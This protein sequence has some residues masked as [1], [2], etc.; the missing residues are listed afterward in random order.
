M[1]RPQHFDNYS[2]IPEIV[3][4]VFVEPGDA[5]Y[6]VDDE[7]EIVSWNCDEWND[8]PEAVTATVNAVALAVS[9]GAN[10]VRENIK[11]EG[12]VLRN[13]IMDTDDSRL[14]DTQLEQ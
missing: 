14:N 10:A 2:G 3:P 9:K 12:Q 4:G 11:Q 5:V 13:L 1:P 7:G 8:D 6:I